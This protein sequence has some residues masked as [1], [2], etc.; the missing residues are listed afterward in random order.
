[1][2]SAGGLV[3]GAGGHGG[4]PAELVEVGQA[5]VQGLAAAHRHAC[6]GAMIAIGKHG[7][8]GLDEGDDLL[9][10]VVVIRRTVGRLGTVA[11]LFVG[12]RRGRIPLGKT[13][14]NGCYFFSASRLSMMIGARARCVHSVLVLPRP[15]WR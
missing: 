8:V 6:D 11:L 1:M 3:F 4:D 12:Q 10:Q 2:S 5:D 7:I 9:Q 15:C 13:M 14:M